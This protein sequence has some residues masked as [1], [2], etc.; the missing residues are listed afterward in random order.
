MFSY[1]ANAIL[2]KARAMYSERIRLKH[3]R[4]LLSCKDVSQ[5]I[6]YLKNKTVYSKII[7]PTGEETFNRI[8]F[9]DRLKRQLFFD[10]EV[11][12][13]YD[14]SIANHFFE[15]IITRT[16][17]E[18][19]T[20][21]LIFLYSD[22]SE[23]NFYEIPVFF[24]KHTKIDLLKLKYVRSYDDILSVV[25]NS[26]YFEI[27]K[28][29]KPEA[30]KQINLTFIEIALQTY[31]Y[32]TIFA[33]I[34]KYLRG[35]AHE[36]LLNLFRDYIDLLNFVKIFRMKKYYD[37]TTDYMYACL[38][39]L[40]GISN[41][42]LMKFLEMDDNLVFEEIKKTKLGRKWFGKKIKIVYIVDCAAFLSILFLP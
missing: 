24:N 41:K 36:E 8:K 28:R 13:R 9:E 40:G 4:E 32:E 7:A 22:K 14:L 42:K 33:L 17:V 23:E 5:V 6:T 2:S 27:L 3:Y 1:A 21:C 29:F 20:K 16:E 11:L 18:I 26:K 35:N 37:L 39:N 15:Y 25:K 19:I 30:G 34:D 10:F 12:G 38:F 31:L